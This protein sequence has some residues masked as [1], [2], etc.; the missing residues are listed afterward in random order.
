MEV[1][2]PIVASAPGSMKNVN[3]VF[4][5]AL[6]SCSP[7]DPGFHG[8]LEI[9]RADAQTLVHLAHVDGDAAVNRVHLRF[10]G[11]AC[12][13]RNHR[14]AVFR[15]DLQDFADLFG[16]VREADDVG[17]SGRMVRLAVAVVLANDFRRG[18]APAEQSPTP[19]WL[20]A[21]A[22]GWAE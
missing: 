2:P 20:P 15:A 14:H 10:H 5:S 17:Q 21:S 8:G 13:E 19:R 9:L 16:R 1:I 7:R 3:P 6:M 12:A 11:R 4:A 18:R 22:R